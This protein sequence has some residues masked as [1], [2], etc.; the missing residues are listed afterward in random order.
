M[1]KFYLV[2]LIWGVLFS[3]KPK[4]SAV[5]AP[6]PEPAPAVV[7][8]W[9]HLFDGSSMDAWK[10]WKKDQPGTAW[11]IEDGTLT[12]DPTSED[13][14]DLLTRKTYEDFE[15][16]LD[17]K[18]AKC[19]NSGLMWNVQEADEYDAPYSTGPEMQILD[20]ACHP[21][22]KIVT[23]RAGD[24]YDMIETNVVNVNPA[25]QWNS[26]I[27]KSKD[28]NY[29]LWQN[30]AKVVEFQMHTPA[31]DKMVENSKFNGWP[32]FGKF[33]SG[34]ICLQDHNDRI[35]FRNIKIKTL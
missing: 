9:E 24:L 30:G 1:K 18:I 23:H 4:E 22:A 12:F 26:I 29:E 20:N 17:W 6:T 28:A 34:H 8:E 27:I 25:E 14:G 16:H 31:W 15:L 35:W 11:S 5:E 19:G 32:G 13:Q 33:K 2:A 7:D 3:C 21:D 10:G